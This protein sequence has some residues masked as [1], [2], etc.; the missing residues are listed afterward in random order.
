[1]TVPPLQFYVWRRP[2][3]RGRTC[4]RYTE[5]RR[6]GQHRPDRPRRC[7]PSLARA[8]GF[9]GRAAHLYR[10]RG[11]RGARSHHPQQAAHRRA[12]ITSSRRRR[13]APRSSIASRTIPSL[14][15]CEV[16]VI[17]HDS[18]LQP[19][20][21]CGA[22]RAGKASAVA[23]G[24]AARRRSISAARAA[25]RACASARASRC[26]STATPRRSSTCPPSA[27]RC[28]STNV[29]KPN[30]RVRVTFTDSKGA[31]RCNGAI[32]WAS[33]EMPKGQ[34]TRYRAGIDLTGADP[35]VARRIRGPQQDER[36]STQ[37]VPRVRSRSSRS[38]PIRLVRAPESPIVRA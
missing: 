2:T 35:R 32:A 33:F 31:I 11:A 16:R 8:A 23:R 12:R 14:A 6:V 22:D 4:N 21:A 34:P 10:R 9:R 1:M 26:W 15:E 17:A 20:R 30:Q 3:L 28:V 5:S 13:A 37:S 18:A 29:L 25:R 36:S 7:A 24:R 38:P 19:R 27:R